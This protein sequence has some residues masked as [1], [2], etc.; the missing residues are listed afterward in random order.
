[1]T[2]SGTFEVKLTPQP[3]TDAGADPL[4]S[5]LSIEKQFYGE[6]VATGRGEM[7]AAR[8]TVTGSAGYV[9]IEQVTGALLGRQGTFVL[10]HSGTMTRDVQQ[11]TVSVVPD[12]AT[13]ELAGLSGTMTIRIA[14]GKHFYEFT[15]MLE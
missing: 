3:L 7:L 6:L 13:G 12:S 9:V 1:M 4:L 2:A 5:R 11:L 15:Y 8:T 14:D 10:Q